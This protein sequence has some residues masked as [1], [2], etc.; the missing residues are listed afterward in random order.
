MCSWCYTLRPALARL[1]EALGKNTE[2]VRLLGG[3]AKDSD[4]PMPAQTRSYVIA[5]WQRIEQTVP[6]TVFNY[7]FWQTC[8][9]RRSTYPACRAVIA[10]RR[11]GDPADK[12]DTAMTEAIQNA[13]YRPARN[14]SDHSTLVELAAELSLDKD[15]FSADLCAEETHAA[16]RQEMNGT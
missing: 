7:D 3:L 6:G 14:P 8:Q 4:E 11:Q 5:N 2:I 16:L 10:A 15:Q 12:L 13:Y 9:P 1:L